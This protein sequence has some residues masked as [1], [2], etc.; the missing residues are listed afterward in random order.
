MMKRNIRTLLAGVLLVGTLTAPAFA[1]TTPPQLP[2]GAYS[3]QD[4][5]PYADQFETYYRI[6]NG[7]CQYRIWNMTKAVW[8]ND[9]TN[10]V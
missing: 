7:V 5:V 9:W 1:V 8:V 10:C 4:I 3:V 2:Q 6:Y